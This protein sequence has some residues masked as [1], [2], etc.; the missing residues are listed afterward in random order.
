MLGQSDGPLGSMGASQV[1]ALELAEGDASD[2]LARV[3]AIGVARRPALMVYLYDAW[4]LAAQHL[5]K[6]DVLEV[7]PRN[8]SPRAC[9]GNSNAPSRALCAPRQPFLLCA[10]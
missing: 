5:A 8:P 6:G 9:A 4:A 7:P 3:P 2:P 1:M 10:G